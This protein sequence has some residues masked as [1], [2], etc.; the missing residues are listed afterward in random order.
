MP[1][2]WLGTTSMGWAPLEAFSGCVFFPFP[3]FFPVHIQGYIYNDPACYTANNP[4]PLDH[5]VLVVGYNFQGLGAPGSFFHILNS[6]GDKWGEKGYMRIGISSTPGG[7]CG[8]TSQ[9]GLYPVLSCESR[10][11]LFELKALL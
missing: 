11:F 10:P 6:W 9:P 2:W 3:F 5:A 1:C 7:V 4:L 8:I